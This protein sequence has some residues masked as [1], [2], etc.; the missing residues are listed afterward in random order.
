ML[1]DSAELPGRS[2]T[3]TVVPREGATHSWES[4]SEPSRLGS[5]ALPMFTL[6]PISA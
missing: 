1:T 2:R 5:T 4:R 6:L 3:A